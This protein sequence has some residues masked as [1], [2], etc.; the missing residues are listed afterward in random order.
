[1]VKDGQSIQ[2]FTKLVFVAEAIHRE[3]SL[4]GPR[5]QKLTQSSRPSGAQGKL[6]QVTDADKKVQKLK[7]PWQVRIGYQSL[8]LKNAWASIPSTAWMNLE[9]QNH[10]DN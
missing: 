3:C 10:N 8:I 7:K 5:G 9:Y 1:V 6:W 4:P 2:R